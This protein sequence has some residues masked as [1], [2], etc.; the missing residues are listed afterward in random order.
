MPRLENLRQNSTDWHDWRRGGLGSSDA[1]VVMGNSPWM[2]P[3]K[4]W[5]IK[6]N[7]TQEPDRDNIATRRGRQLE[8]AARAAYERE[9]AEIM[10]PHCVS[11]DQ[12]SWMRA[13]LDGLNLEGSLVLE[14]KCPLSS[15]D[16]ALALEGQVPGHYYAQLQ[17]QLEV[18][19]ACELH[20]WSFD[21]RKG[22]LVK[23]IPDHGYIE[24]LIQAEIDFWRR[25]TENR[26]PQ[27]RFKDQ[28]LSDDPKWSEA[29]RC[30]R[31]VRRR[32]DE[33]SNQEREL[34]GRLLNLS[35]ARRAFGSGVELIR[36][37]RKGAVNY[38]A[39]PELEGVDLEQYR[40]DPVDV[41][42]ISIL[43]SS[44]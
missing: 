43:A 12:L 20:Y 10:E 33:L 17:H 25:V 28:D 11:H 5:E 21:G 3:R 38:G 7:R 26:W 35:D 40:K 37:C 36:T 23:V 30:Y 24:R 2:M 22:A 18:S 29:A 27:P 16:H 1:P 15:R 6:T 34:R 31:R 13:S 42:K 4:L 8:A 41:V 14:I 44:E 32:L 9:T 19:H 39:I